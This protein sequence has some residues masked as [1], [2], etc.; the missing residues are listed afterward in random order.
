MFR[1]R[2][3]LKDEAIH[4][5]FDSFLDLVTNVVGII[6][7]LILVTWIGARSYHATM[8]WMEVEPIAPKT[9]PK[10]TDD[11]LHARMEQ[12][13]RDLDDAKTRLLDQLKMAGELDVSAQLTETQL[14][15]LMRRREQ[16]EAERAHLQAKGVL[17]DG[18]LVQ[19]N[20]SVEDVRK[21][22]RKLLDEIK[23]LESAPSKKK[24]LKYH[25][26]VSQAVRSEELFFECKAGR[27]T[28]IDLPSFLAEYKSSLEEI[29]GELK[30]KWRVERVTA[31]VGPYRLRYLVE[32]ERSPLDA[33]TTPGSGSFRYGLGAWEV[34]PISVNRGETVEQALREKSEF[35]SLVDP[36]DPRLTVV[37]FWVY[38][39]SFELFRKLRDHLY[40]RGHDVAGR[41][42]PM[43]TPIAASKHGSASR[44]Q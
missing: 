24:E 3:P 37:T 23:Q 18:K 11:P 5:S 4:F 25:A 19:A 39:D 28:Y 34:E 33:G 16:L 21:R 2:R 32:R 15:S 9:A 1:R 6:I 17:R 14:A 10:V 30:T 40:E 43:G 41:P 42:L 44:G 29:S 38:P 36:L 8:T 20:L 12:A 22:S 7:R 31:P 13:S 26:P 35:R 27:V